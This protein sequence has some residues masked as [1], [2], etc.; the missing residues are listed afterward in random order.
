MLKEPQNLGESEIPM[1]S[2]GISYITGRIYNGVLAGPYTI[3]GGGGGVTLIIDYCTSKVLSA[4]EVCVRSSTSRSR[5][6]ATL[7]Q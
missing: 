3:P 4:G 7:V 5:A 2:V 1:S 6:W